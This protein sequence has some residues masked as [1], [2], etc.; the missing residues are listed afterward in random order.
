M[1]GTAGAFDYRS[2][3]GGSVP[4]T[5]QPSVKVVNEQNTIA[6][7]SEPQASSSIDA[8]QVGPATTGSID[9][10]VAHE[11]QTAA[12][13][14]PV[15]VESQASRLLG[16]GPTLAADQAVPKQPAQRAAIATDQP[17]PP[18]ASS[19]FGSGYA[20]QVTSERSEAR[21]Q[22]AFRALQAKFPDQLSGR[23]ATIRRADLGTA[24]TY[25]R[26]LVGPFASAGKAAK[27]CNGLKAAGGNCLILKN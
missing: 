3:F 4:P 25:Y 7:L 14:G 9:N 26:A 8:R 15:K 17:E 20:V 6:S 23:Q 27:L 18:P 19:V 13:V 22:S 24:G 12:S 16:N 10:K 21:A 1:V 5:L 11:R 2:M